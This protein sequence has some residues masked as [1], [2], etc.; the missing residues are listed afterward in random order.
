MTRTMQFAKRH[1]NE[2]CQIN[3]GLR[4]GGEMGGVSIFER[5]MEK[6]M[7]FFAKTTHGK[8]NN[9]KS[10]K[11]T[12]KLYNTITHNIKARTKPPNKMHKTHTIT[13][14]NDQK[15]IKNIHFVQFRVDYELVR[16]VDQF[17]FCRLNGELSGGAAVLL[18]S[19][20]R[21]QQ[22]GPCSINGASLLAES[23]A[24]CLQSMMQS[25]TQIINPSTIQS[26]NQ[27]KYQSI[28]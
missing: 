6:P 3:G 23:G 15:S 9:S 14:R 5:G 16:C 24:L 26:I 27:I 1:Q 7:F 2:T 17:G 13:E 20:V 8:H 12:I 18:P 22:F 4:G 10:N 11:Q 28:K 21:Q 19:F 25:I